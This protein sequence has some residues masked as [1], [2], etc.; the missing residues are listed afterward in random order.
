MAA[1]ALTVRCY[2]SAVYAVVVCPFVRHMPVL[3]QNDIGN[4]NQRGLCGYAWKKGLGLLWAYKKDRD[5]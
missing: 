4:N 5:T 2:A 3:Y 1:L